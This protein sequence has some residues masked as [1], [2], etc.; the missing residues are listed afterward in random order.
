MGKPSIQG[1]VQTT[2]EAHPQIYAYTTPEIRRHDGWTKIGYT[3][4]PVEVRLAQQTHTADVRCELQWCGNATYEDTGK[5]FKDTN[6]HS[7]LTKL[8]I[9]R[10]PKTEWFHVEPTPAKEHFRD[11]RENHGIV[12]GLPTVEYCLRDEQERA[13][14]GAADY[15]AAHEG[16]EYLWN[17]KPRF[18]KTLASYDL[19]KRELRP[20]QE[21]GCQEGPHRHQP[22]GNRELLVRRLRDFHGAG[23]RLR[24]R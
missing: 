9:D 4:Q 5:P 7:Y 24:L 8:G 3:E 20:L 11:F 1:K 2:G 14:Q 17:A 16:G 21:S 15:A 18:G 19:C 22:P 10:I 23:I 12:D 6:L 13:C